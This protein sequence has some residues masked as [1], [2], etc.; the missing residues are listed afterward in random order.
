[1]RW[2]E[3]IYVT[4]GPQLHTITRF[5]HSATSPFGSR[6]DTVSSRSREPIGECPH[7]VMGKGLPRQFS[8]PRSD[9]EGSNRGGEADNRSPSSDR[10][11]ITFKGRTYLRA[12]TLGLSNPEAVADTWD[13]ENLSRL[14]SW[15]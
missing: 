1:M 11:D 14:D 8:P 2:I 13:D 4:V 12:I 10:F 5:V 7:G 15:A 3:H 9:G 6:L